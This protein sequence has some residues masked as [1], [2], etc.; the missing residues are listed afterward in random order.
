MTATDRRPRAPRAAGSSILA[1]ASALLGLSVLAPGSQAS[2]QGVAAAAE[3]P[4]P[5]G[6]GGMAGELS[7]SAYAQLKWRLVGPFRGGWATMAAGVAASPDT[8]YFS[9]AGGGIWKT[10]DAGRTWWSVGDSLPPAIGALAIAPS[11]PDTIYVGTGQVSLRYDLAAGRGVF[12]STDGG[13]TWKSL[14]LAATRD[15]GRIWVD[16]R[17]PDIV[18][19]GALGHLFGPNAERGIYRSTLGPKR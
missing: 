14:G 16:P 8:F 18:V 19:V 15:I 10:Q 2:A 1:L 5:Q 7:P 17:N 6:R 12:K 9:G 4:F 13:K 3:V 11:A